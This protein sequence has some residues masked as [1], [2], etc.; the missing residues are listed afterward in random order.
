MAE[1]RPELDEIIRRP[2][3]RRLTGLS[4]ATIFRLIREKKFPAPV[5]LSKSA[6]GWLVSQVRAWQQ[7]LR[8]TEVGTGAPVRRDRN[9]SMSRR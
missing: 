5:A 1:D 6:K 4:D 2:A 3:L 7:S 9:R 8:P